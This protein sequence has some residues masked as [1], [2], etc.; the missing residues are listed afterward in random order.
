MTVAYHH[1]VVDV[2]ADYSGG[3]VHEAYFPLVADRTYV[4]YHGVQLLTENIIRFVPNVNR[5]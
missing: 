2:D 3:F 4:H 5:K 1:G